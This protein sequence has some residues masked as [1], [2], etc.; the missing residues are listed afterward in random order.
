MTE[1]HAAS[2]RESATV[3]LGDGWPGEPDLPPPGPGYHVTDGYPH[4]E[5]DPRNWPHHEERPRRPPPLNP[6]D[7]LPPPGPDVVV[8][9]LGY[10]FSLNPFK[11]LIRWWRRRPT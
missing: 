5:T 8:Y 4:R 10:P 1:Q 9:G 3:D 11:A 2:E 6:D 7:D